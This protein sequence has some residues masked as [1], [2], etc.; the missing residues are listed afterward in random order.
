M[1]KPKKEKIFEDDFVRIAVG[2]G[3]CKNCR[4]CVEFCPTGCLE[5]V[6]YVA[7][8]VKIGECIGCGMCEL[9]CPDFC[10]SVVKKAKKRAKK[11]G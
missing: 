3:W 1:A 9:R 5:M 11:A 2:N 10:I 8:P 4:I 7:V 6:E